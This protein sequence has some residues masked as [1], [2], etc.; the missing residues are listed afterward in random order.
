MQRR[1][2]VALF[3]LATVLTGYAGPGIALASD[4]LPE[5][6]SR[7]GLSDIRVV[8]KKK[9]HYGRVVL[10][11]LADGTPLEIDLDRH[12]AIKDVEVDGHGGFP[13]KAIETLIPPAVRAHASYPASAT[14][15]RVEFDDDGEIEIEGRHADGGKFKAEYTTA[16]KL[17]EMKAD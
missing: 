15:Y 10:G 3:G 11:R 14:F 17:I 9:D 2:S 12:D 4:A 6:V 16:G 5:A 1:I 7:L 8:S 13:A